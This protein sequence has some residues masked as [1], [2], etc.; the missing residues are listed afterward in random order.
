MAVTR[1]S[2]EGYGYVTTDLSNVRYRVRDLHSDRLIYVIGITQSQH[3]E[4]VRET[5]RL[6][7]WL[8]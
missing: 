1:K 2:E 8:P 3:L 7:G 5:A 4:M 6:A